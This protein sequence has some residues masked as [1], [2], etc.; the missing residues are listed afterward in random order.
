MMPRPVQRLKENIGVVLVKLPPCKLNGYAVLCCERY[1]L[2]RL[3]RLGLGSDGFAFLAVDAR[4]ESGTQDRIR[5]AP[6]RFRPERKLNRGTVSR[7]LHGRRCWHPCRGRKGG[8]DTIRVLKH[9]K[10][11]Q[12]SS[13][14]A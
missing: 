14:S 3:F 8:E 12:R 4:K 2:Q 13:G 7:R 10:R 11:R 6:D 9:V 5:A 1:R